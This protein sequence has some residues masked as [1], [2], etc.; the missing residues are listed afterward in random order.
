MVTGLVYLSKLI[1]KS[2]WKWEQQETRI[3]D[4]GGLSRHL[5]GAAVWGLKAGGLVSSLSKSLPPS[6][7]SPPRLKTEDCSLELLITE[8]LFSRK[9]QRSR[10]EVPT[11]KQAATGSLAA[12]LEDSQSPFPIWF[13]K[14]WRAT[15]SVRM[16][17]DSSLRKQASPRERLTDTGV[18]G[19]LD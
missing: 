5:G 6:H 7:V 13:P 3:W 2:L 11:W 1:A 14:Y 15:P 4:T 12:E 16:V 19:C 17:K 10:A 9:Q 8:D 18:R